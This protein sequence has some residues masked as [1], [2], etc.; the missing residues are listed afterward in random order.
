MGKCTYKKIVHIF[1]FLTFSVLFNDTGYQD[2][3]RVTLV[4]NFSK[5]GLKSV[6][7]FLYAEK[8]CLPYW[9]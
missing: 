9:I 2:M 6:F 8:W 3:K 5:K 4:T 7:W 1:S